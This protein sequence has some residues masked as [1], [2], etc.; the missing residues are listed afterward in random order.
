MNSR[1]NL[2]HSLFIGF[3]A[4]L[5]VVIKS[6]L[7]MK[8]G[9]SGHSMFL[10][11]VFYLVCYGATNKVG[12]MTLCGLLAG[13]L[14]MIL[15]VRK[16]GLFILLKFTLPA[17]AMD[18]G[19]LFIATL[20][21]LRVRLILL[22]SIGSVAWALK[23]GVQD[24]LLGMDINIVLIQFGINCL[25]GGAFAVLGALLV[26]LILKRLDAHDLLIKNGMRDK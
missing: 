16:G 17:I 22:V 1:F 10:M 23:S 13:M 24:I 9:F 20:F 3:C 6:M 21:S 14:A 4:T 7:R 18:I 2:H 26:P 19:L 8:L 25:S 5:L 11:S 15:G 12:S